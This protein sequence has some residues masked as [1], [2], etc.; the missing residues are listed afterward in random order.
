[1]SPSL[2][3]IAAG[4]S[5]DGES[6][7]RGTGCANARTSGSVG[8]LG[9]NTQ[10]HPARELPSECRTEASWATDCA[11]RTRPHVPRSG[12]RARGHHLKSAR[13]RR[14]RGNG[15][16][17]QFRGPPPDGGLELRQFGRAGTRVGGRAPPRRLHPGA[18]CRIC[19]NDIDLRSYP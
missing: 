3:R 15:P 9:G 5:V 8:A 18:A 16:R 11:L 17:R 19:L 1:M 4:T 7:G 12:I 13:W 2:D 6:V 14:C 10:G